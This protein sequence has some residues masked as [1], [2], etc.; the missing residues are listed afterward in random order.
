[1]SAHGPWAYA[2]RRCGHLANAHEQRAAT[3]DWGCAMCGCVAAAPLDF[4]EGVSERVARASHAEEL[5]WIAERWP[6]VSR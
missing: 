2:C 6:G 1:M 4:K 5:A 3:E